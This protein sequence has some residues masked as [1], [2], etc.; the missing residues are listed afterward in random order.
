MWV[1]F[2]TGYNFNTINF[3]RIMPANIAT[4]NACLHYDFDWWNNTKF[5]KKQFSKPFSGNTCLPLWIY[6]A[7]L[8]HINL[9]WKFLW[10]Y[11]F[12]SVVQKEM[13]KIQFP[14]FYLSLYHRRYHWVNY[15]ITFLPRQRWYHPPVGCLTDAFAI[16]TVSDV[17]YIADFCANCPDVGTW[18]FEGICT[19]FRA[20]L[21]TVPSI[22]LVG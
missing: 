13:N 12:L 19:E 5:G 2:E 14:I 11:V 8:F 22:V 4:L 21:I 18:I 6:F 16:C 15:V 1:R 20:H 10:G 9:L 3:L 7:L 17:V